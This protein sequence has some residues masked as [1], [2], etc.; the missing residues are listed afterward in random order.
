MVSNGLQFS[1]SWLCW[2]AEFTGVVLSNLVQALTAAVVLLSVI[3][4]IEQPV[5]WTSHVQSSETVNNLVLTQLSVVLWQVSAVS[6]KYFSGTS[7]FIAISISSV[8]YLCHFNVRNSFN[9]RPIVS[10]R[11]HRSSQRKCERQRRSAQMR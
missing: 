2:Y 1:P 4:I 7:S 5:Q 8:S 11:S 3:R 6:V 9:S 10:D